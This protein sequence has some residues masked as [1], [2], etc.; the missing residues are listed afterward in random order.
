M[1]HENEFKKESSLEN[2]DFE[3]SLKSS[4]IRGDF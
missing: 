2:F 1:E 3:P 4:A